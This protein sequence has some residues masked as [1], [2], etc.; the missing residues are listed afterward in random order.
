MYNLWP[1]Q[2]RVLQGGLVGRTHMRE[3]MAERKPVSLLSL[4][5]QF[6]ETV[7]S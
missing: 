7:S 5:L 2:Y 6:M 3:R 1:I 4:L